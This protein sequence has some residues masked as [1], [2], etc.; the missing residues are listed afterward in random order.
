MAWRYARRSV[1][2]VLQASLR[3]AVVPKRQSLFDTTDCDRRLD[4]PD[5]TDGGTMRLRSVS[6]LIAG[7]V[8]ITWPSASATG[9]QLCSAPYFVEQSF[10]VGGAAQT[11]WRICWQTQPGWGLMI[12]SAHFRKSPNAPFMRVFWDAYVS[13]IFVP[14][15]PG[16]PR[17]YDLSGFGFD[18]TS[19]SAADCPAAVGGAVLAG[20]VCKEVHDRGLLWKDDAQVRLG[21]EVVLWSAIDAANYNYIVEWTFRDDGVILGRLGATAVNL[22]AIPLTAHMHNAVWRVESHRQRV[23]GR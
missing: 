7:C 17:F 2:P 22:P 16:S 19:V 21:H 18:V 10:P 20:R 1:R 9:Q 4:R 12:T 13:D 5:G 23:L 8:S 6:L 15:H 11:T 14:Y 3:A